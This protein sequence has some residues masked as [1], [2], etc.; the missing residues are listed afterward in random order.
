LGSMGSM[1]YTDNSKN[2]I[3]TGT[4]LNE[5]GQSLSGI[6]IINLSNNFVAFTNEKGNFK[7]RGKKKDQLIVLYPHRQIT[8][9]VQKTKNFVIHLKEELKKLDEKTLLSSNERNN[10]KNLKIISGFLY[11]SDGFEIPDAE[12][13]V[14]G[15]SI[16]TITNEQGFY[17]LKAS[18]GEVLLV[19]NP[20]GASQEFIITSEK[21]NLKF[22]S[23]VLLESEV[24]VAGFSSEPKTM[25]SSS[26]GEVL[27]GKIAGLKIESDKKGSV[28]I[29]GMSSLSEKSGT[30]ISGA[31][32]SFGVSNSSVQP[33]QLTAGEVNDFSHWN[34]WQ[35]LTESEWNQWKNHWNF[36]PTARYSVILTNKEGFP[37]FNKVLHLKNASNKILWTSITDN[38]GRAELW[39]NPHEILTEN[40]PIKLSITDDKNNILTTNPIEFKKGINLYTYQEKCKE[41]NKVNIAFMV[42][43]TGSMG[44]ELRYLQAELYDVIERTK[45]AMPEID[46]SMG[47]VF[48]RDQGD[49]YVVKNFDFTSHIPDL[50]SFIQKQNA[51]GGGDFPE[52]VVEAF[53]ASIEQLSWDQDA[54]TKLLFVL[55]DAP[56]HHNKEN[57]AK[58]QKLTLKAA[59]N[60]IRIIPIAGSGI[61]KSTEFLMRAIALETNG[62]YLFLTDHSGI[63][64][65]HLEPSTESYKVEMF[66]DLL[67]RIIKQFTEVKTCFQTEF[68]PENNKFEN[69]INEETTI[70]WSFS[71]NPTSSFVHVKISKEASEIH[72][73]DTTGKL[74]FYQNH[75]AKNYQLNLTGL[76]TAVYYLRIIVDGKDLYGKL[77]KK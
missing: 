51:D 22:K 35:G 45:S 1:E 37:I 62:T 63:G 74:I 17:T 26:V 59:E 66:N 53:E 47:S 38:T 64:N 12:I 69:K 5:E 39:L 48:Y 57:V 42:D 25:A 21:M 34:Y 10:S 31:S 67:L 49:E 6:E 72:L 65:P 9:E 76:P 30:I 24:R 20:I 32:S 2:G 7:I 55:L 3:I 29:R 43:A 14:R 15:T 71:P 60:G 61:D 75:R 46:L 19:I 27:E 77:I 58:L 41:L 52:A 28:K 8:I 11:D 13:S 23:E 50:I 73:L 54:K 68:Y 33:G 40:S 16:S 36:N 56:P 44:D 70:Q 4:I 18:I